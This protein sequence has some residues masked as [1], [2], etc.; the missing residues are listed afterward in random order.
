MAKS[1]FDES[2]E[3]I[4][5]LLPKWPLSKSETSTLLKVIYHLVDTRM[6]PKK[7]KP[8]LGTPL[9]WETYSQCYK[10]RYNGVEPPKNAK[11]MGLCANLIKLVGLEKAK[12]LVQ[13]YFTQ[14]DSFYQTKSYNLELLLRDYTTLYSR[15]Y[16]GEKI[17][18]KTAQAHEA[19]ANT[20][21]AI[22]A[23]LKE[24]Y[25]K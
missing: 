9:L 11:N 24:K 16:S 5:A 12:E 20:Q 8:P 17:T 15:L 10:A 25:Q 14:K 19:K 7:K 13:F 18:Y 2:A 4:V 3:N 1:Q 21:E 22:V 6:A 23:H